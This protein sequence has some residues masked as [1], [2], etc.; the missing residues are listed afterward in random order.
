MTISLTNIP[1]QTLLASRWTAMW[2]GEFN[3]EQIVSA[4]CAVYFGRTP[5]SD[6]AAIVSGPDALQSV[7]EGTRRR[8][9]GVHFSF[10]SEPLHQ[11]A[12]ERN[13]VITLLWTLEAPGQV[14]KTGIDLLRH[15]GETIVEVWSITGDHELPP[16]R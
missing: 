11:P 14:R 3:A 6:R 7:I 8:I 10:E 5:Q 13:G 16:M 9:P 4:D 1:L 2:N 12:G 15:R